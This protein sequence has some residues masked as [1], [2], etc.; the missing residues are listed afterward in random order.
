METIGRGLSGKFLKKMLDRKSMTN[1]PSTEKKIKA[2]IS[3]HKSALSR[4]KKI[5][6]SI[7]DIELGA[8][9]SVWKEFERNGIFSI[10]EIRKSKGAIVNSFNSLVCRVAELGYRNN[11]YNLL[12]RG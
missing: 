12:F 8:P 3:S 1:N 2:K 4:E 6:G 7:N 11:R 9:P 10:S 5:Y